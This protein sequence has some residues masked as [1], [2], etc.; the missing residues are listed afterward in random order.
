MGAG[1]WW[2][3][4]A[5]TY[6]KKRREPLTTAEEILKHEEGKERLQTAM[7]SH[8]PGTVFRWEKLVKFLGID[9]APIRI[10]ID[11]VELKRMLKLIYNGML[12]WIVWK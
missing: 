5:P 7:D 12:V 4:K 6:A 3:K 1:A 10:D 2:R 9:L 11:E 8:L